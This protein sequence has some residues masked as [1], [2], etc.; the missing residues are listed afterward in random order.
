MRT[1]RLS[2]DQKI[3][4]IG[5]L[6]VVAVCRDFLNETNADHPEAKVMQNSLK[7]AVRKFANWLRVDESLAL[8]I[9]I[10]LHNIVGV[11]FEPRRG[12]DL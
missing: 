8:E 9:L 6:G 5:C 7:K 12:D 2:E 1:V 4:L 11:G 3:A 10:D